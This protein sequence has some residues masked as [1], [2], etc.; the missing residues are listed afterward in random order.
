MA[1]LK[2]VARRAGVSISTVSYVLNGKAEKMRISRET[3]EQVLTI[4][5]EMNYQPNVQARRLKDTSKKGPV[6]AV[7]WDSNNGGSFLARFMVGAQNALINMTQEFE[8]VILPYRAEELHR[9]SALHSENM[10]NGA[11]IANVGLKDKDY[12]ENTDISLPIVLFN[13]LSKKYSSVY[14][15]EE[16]IGMIAARHMIQA[17]CRHFALVRPRLDLRILE[18]RKEGFL[19]VC[20]ENG[21]EMDPELIMVSDY[22]LTG[23]A[24]ATEEILRRSRTVDGI[25]YLTDMMAA[26]GVNKLHELHKSVPEEIKI[27]SHGDNVYSRCTYPSITCTHLPV[28]EM[29]ENGIRMLIDG[30]QEGKLYQKRDMEFDV[31]LVKRGSC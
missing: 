8:V 13:R 23:G 12:L 24:E 31:N 4:A 9:V 26:G 11:L 7:L 19:K 22:S 1:N 2:D 25:Y 14:T 15:S 5:K 21:I 16:R 10:Y 17:G 3:R 20:R 30:Y 27:M 29:S 28:E 18:P 6:F